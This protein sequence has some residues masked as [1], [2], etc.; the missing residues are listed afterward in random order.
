ML[1]WHW[2]W[3]SS[4]VTQLRPNL[5]SGSA[6]EEIVKRADLFKI[7]ICCELK[8][9]ISLLRPSIGMSK[10]TVVVVTKCSR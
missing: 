3:W 4:D 2:C 7:Q 9:K 1:R 6:Q 5:C 10:H 8:T